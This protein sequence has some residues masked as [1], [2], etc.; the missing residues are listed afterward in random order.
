MTSVDKKFEISNPTNSS[1]VKIKFPSGKGPMT[2]QI[3][4]ILVVNEFKG[5]LTT[6]AKIYG[7]YPV[8]TSREEIVKKIG[9]DPLER[10]SSIEN[11]IL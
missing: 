8:N 6:S 5:I 3:H 1:Q 7:M 11:A 10:R 4:C 2:W 9:R